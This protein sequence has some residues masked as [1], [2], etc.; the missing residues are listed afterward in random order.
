[1]PRPTGL[2]SAAAALR[3]YERR[4]ETAAH[5]LANVSTDGFRGERAFATLMSDGVAA[6][7]TATDARAG[8]LRETHNPLDLAI[9]GDG[10]FVVGT[11]AGERLTRA[12]SFRVDGDRRLVDA[13]GDPVLGDAGPIT[14]PAG[15]EVAVDAD[16][17]VRV[18]GRAAGRLRL[19]RVAPGAQMAHEGGV[20]FVPDPSRAPIPAAERRVRQGYVEESNVAPVTALVDMIA[21]Q[22]AYAHVQK[23]V[24]VMDEVR[25]TAAGELGKPV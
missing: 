20:R 2:T 18:D 7:R 6:V 25:G 14:L 10:F 5:N 11:A 13:A 16:G 4:Q 21:V 9:P 17:T 15:R 12:G 24:T 3:Y 8:T 19:E 23:A 1:M 22:R